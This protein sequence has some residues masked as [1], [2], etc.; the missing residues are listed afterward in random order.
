MLSLGLLA[1]TAADADVQTVKLTT[2]RTVGETVSFE[3][4]A[5]TGVTVDWGDGDA[6]SYP[7]GEVT[8][9]L[10]AATF[11]VK[12]DEFLTSLLVPDLDLTEL[13]VT[14]A[15]Q[16]LTLD[17]SNNHLKQ[18]GLSRA[19]F[20][21][22]L[23]C[24]NNEIEELG[25]INC[26]QLRTLNC[27][28]NKLTSITLT[29]TTN[30]EQLICDNNQL[31]SLTLVSNPYLQTVWCNNNG[32]ESL[33]ITRS[34]DL[35]SLYC[36]DNKLTDIIVNDASSLEDVWCENNS[37]ESIDFGS[38]TA[39]NTFNADN[40]QLK[41]VTLGGITANKAPYLISYANN[42][43]KLNS[44]YPSKSVDY[45]FYMPQDTIQFAQDSVEVNKFIDFGDYMN[46]ALGST[47]GSISFFRTAD[48]SELVKGVGAGYDYYQR[49]A[50]IKFW[51]PQ[52]E[53]YAVITSSQFPELRLVTTPFVA[54]SIAEGIRTLQAETS[55]EATLYDLQG[56]PVTKPQGGI[57]VKD[58]KKVFVK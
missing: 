51:R 49:S 12:G 58:G 29:R 5:M 25:L 39:L 23:D 53:I 55:G 10:K 9:V 20:L 35:F 54:G 27:A 40:N 28:S 17:C 22:E 37:L 38:T 48:D 14:E 6:V 52:G 43:L 1:W 4:S 56:R 57:Y 13:D 19:S 34:G 15:N 2:Q 44:F 45:Y 26:V 41:Q 30:L 47:V 50:T 16:L 46:N 42:K 24:S 36:P 32:M 31:T 3:V 8:G 18:L 11:T 7:D 33:S 21:R